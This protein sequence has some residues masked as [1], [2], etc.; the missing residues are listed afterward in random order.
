M[1][2]GLHQGPDFE[3]AASG[4][5]PASVTGIL[6]S[7]GNTRDGLDQVFS[8]LYSELKPIARRL[9]AGSGSQTIS[10]TVLVHEAY[11]KLIGSESLN[12]E[13][14]RHF[15]AL[16]ARTMRQ[17]VVDYARGRM[18]D[19]RGGGKQVVSLNE[20]GV[21]DLGQPE[22]LVAMDEA[23][24]WLEAHDPRLVD[25]VQFR[26]YAGLSLPEIA[27]LLDVTPRQLQRDWLR[28]RAWL[29]EALLGAGD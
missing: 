8:L 16:C 2:G 21:I 27:P 3:H 25:L 6:N 29:T 5:D 1:A 23:L 22:S 19:K 13:G 11:A 26:V 28:A 17:I 4:M 20:E 24:S 12:V 14:R 7:A 18:T 15:F 10:P 9:L